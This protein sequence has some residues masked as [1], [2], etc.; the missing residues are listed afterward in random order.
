LGQLKIKANMSI[1]TQIKTSKKL[2]KNKND[3]CII[4]V[5]CAILMICIVF[6]ALFFRRIVACSSY[7]ALL[8]RGCGMLFLGGLEKLLYQLLGVGA[9]C[10]VW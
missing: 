2:L 3:F 10:V 5:V 9:F 8:V 4:E 6:F 1:D 7:L